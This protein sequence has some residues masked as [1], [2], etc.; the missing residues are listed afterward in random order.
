MRKL[1]ILFILVLLVIPVFAQDDDACSAEAINAA[2]DELLTDYQ[3]ERP[4]EDAAEVIDSVGELSNELLNLVADCVASEDETETAATESSDG[5]PI[6][7]KWTIQWRTAESVCPDGTT[8]AGID[9][10]FILMVDSENDEII[11]DDILIWPPLEFRPDAEG[12]YKFGRNEPTFTY[13]Y[14]LD[15]MSSDRI[16]GIIRSFIPSI[17]CNLEDTFVMTL[18]DE[19]I[20][21]LVATEFGANLRSGPGTD[22][23]R[24]GTLAVSERTDVIGQA[25]GTDGFVW[26]QLANEAWVRSDLVEEAGY[27]DTVPV[28]EV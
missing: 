22:F 25:T 12:I 21:C 15:E 5:L 8:I 10:P 7:G 16:E 2:V 11:A 19:N 27:C 6:E 18:A 26:W 1:L 13:D 3:E 14:I 20:Q 9:R 4:T 23:N 28:V 24:A 17:N